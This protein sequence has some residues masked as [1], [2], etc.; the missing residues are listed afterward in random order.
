VSWACPSEIDESR[1]LAKNRR[2]ILLCF[3]LF[4]LLC[5]DGLQGS[6]AER[7]AVKGANGVVP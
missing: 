6:F 2:L 4:L 7:L 3:F 5:L 1:M